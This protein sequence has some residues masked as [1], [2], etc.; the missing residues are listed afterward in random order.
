[1]D[2]LRH[3]LITSPGGLPLGILPAKSLFVDATYLV[4][5]EFLS[6]IISMGRWRG[7]FLAVAISTCTAIALLAGPSSALLLIPQTYDNWHAGGATFYLEGSNATTWPSQLESE[8]IGG[9]LCDPPSENVLMGPLTNLSHCVWSGSKAVSQQ[10]QLVTPPTTLFLQDGLVRRNIYVQYYS[11]SAAAFGVSLSPL[12]YS[13][14]INWIFRIAM[15]NAKSAK[16]GTL[17]RLSNLKTRKKEG[18]ATSINSQIP[19]VRTT[20]LTNQSVNF[21]DIVNQVSIDTN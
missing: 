3:Q 6:G 10:W 2:I 7:I 14:V 18:T 17:L 4:S 12:L 8:S 5:H 15:F 20:C 11:L 19:V 16:T 13:R 21:A 9:K 1:M